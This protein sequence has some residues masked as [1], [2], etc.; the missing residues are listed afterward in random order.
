MDWSKRMNLAL[1]YIESNLQGELNIKDIAESAYSSPFHFQRMFHAMIG[2]P[3]AEYI[4]RRRMTLAASELVTGHLR[5]VDIAFKYGYESPN[6]FTRAFRKMHGITPSEAK[7]SNKNLSV[8][9]RATFHSEVKGG[10]EMN[11]RIV[12]KPD[13]EIVG[14]SKLFDHEHFFKEAPRFWKEYVASNDY[15]SLWA[16]NNGRCGPIT[17]TALMSV[18]LPGENGSRDQFKDILS[19]EK[20]A[21]FDTRGYEVFNIPA[22]TYAEF[23]CTYQTAAK[24]NKY[25]YGVWFASTGYERDADKADIAA[26]FPVAF[27]PMKEM[28]V[29]WW[30]PIVMNTSKP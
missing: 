24:M 25:I 7:R 30:I 12:E 5:I 22:A 17:E 2:I 15:S 28:G 14:K 20:Q 18:Y 13:F 21:N 1:D 23:N 3:T 9:H 4:R 26:Y 16:M 29:R 8:Y 10:N 6:A 11:Y 27:R 19:I